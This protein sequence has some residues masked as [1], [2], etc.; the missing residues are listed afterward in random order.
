VR[1]DRPDDVA[2]ASEESFP[3]SDPPS[4]VRTTGSSVANSSNTGST[5]AKSSAVKGARAK[6]SGPGRGQKRGSRGRA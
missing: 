2:E 1:T 6:A 4:F 5:P 3:A